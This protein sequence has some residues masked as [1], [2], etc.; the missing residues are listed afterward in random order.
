MAKKK[1]ASRPASKK[2][3]SA[4]ASNKL[5]FHISVMEDGE[6][7]IDE[8]FGNVYSNRGGK[9]VEWTITS[10]FEFKLDFNLIPYAGLA[11]ATVWPFD[12]PAAVNGNSTGWQDVFKG[13]PGDP[14]VYK[15]DVWVREESTTRL[16]G[17]VDPV[18][19]V[20]RG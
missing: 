17:Y 8:A 20:G 15:Y 2:G 4:T 5:A 11:S 18:I 16:V 10:G 19:I 3:K 1:A 6:V 9:K 12:R 13:D 14:G 7:V